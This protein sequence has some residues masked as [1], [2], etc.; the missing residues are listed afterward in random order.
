MATQ[1]AMQGWHRSSQCDSTS[2]EAWCQAGNG[3]ALHFGSSSCE[4]EKPNAEGYLFDRQ[5]FLFSKRR[6]SMPP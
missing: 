1:Y 4:K 6:R 2:R 3:V 5:A